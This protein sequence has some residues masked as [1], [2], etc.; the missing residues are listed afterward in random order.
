M[1]MAGF[2]NGFVVNISSSGAL[3]SF[4]WKL[5][6]GC[7]IRQSQQKSPH[8]T[9]RKGT[10]LAWKNRHKKQKCMQQQTKTNQ[11]QYEHKTLL[12]DDKTSATWIPYVT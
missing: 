4:L 6:T 12:K 10:K 3:I 1:F 8:I 7:W 9:E 2:F 5:K 11:H